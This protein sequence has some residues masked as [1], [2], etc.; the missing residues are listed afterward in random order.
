MMRKELKE[1]LFRLRVL[2]ATDYL[3]PEHDAVIEETIEL[4]RIMASLVRKSAPKSR[5]TAS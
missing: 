5:T 1:T 2:K 4:K 3:E